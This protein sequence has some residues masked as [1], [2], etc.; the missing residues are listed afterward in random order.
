[1]IYEQPSIYKNVDWLEFGEIARNSW[2]DVSDQLEAM[3][4][5][6]VSAKSFYINE[7]LGLY[8]FGLKAYA[9]TLENT[10]IELVKINYSGFVRASGIALALDENDQ[11]LNRPISFGIYDDDFPGHEHRVVIWASGS[12]Q[13]AGATGISGFGVLK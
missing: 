8:R 12:N 3:P 10:A 7:Y 4:G 2:V 5:I 6:N 9:N 13:A 11:Q 1:M